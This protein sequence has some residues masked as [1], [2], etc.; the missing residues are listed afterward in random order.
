M[1]DPNEHEAMT[2][3]VLPDAVPNSIVTVFQKGYK[4]NGR[5]VRPARVIVAKN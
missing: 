2:V 5:V 3:Q 4:L 1:F